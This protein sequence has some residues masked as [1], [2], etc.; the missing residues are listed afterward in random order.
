MGYEIPPNSVENLRPLTGKE[1][2]RILSLQPEFIKHVD[3]WQDVVEKVYR[4]YNK[5]TFNS[6]DH[7]AKVVEAIIKTDF[8]SVITPFLI[9]ITL[10][11][12]KSILMP[13]F[14]AQKTVPVAKIIKRKRNDRDGD[15]LQND[16]KDF[17][18]EICTKKRRKKQSIL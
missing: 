9:R 4:L 8:I 15:K 3:V 18:S 17:N 7:V 13:Y 10:R 12:L 11:P 1:I 6:F 16:D 14:L 2:L 5:E